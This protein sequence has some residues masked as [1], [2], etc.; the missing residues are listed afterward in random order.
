MIYQISPK[1]RQD[2]IV[3]QLEL[4]ENR[5]DQE[6]AV[7]ASRRRL[8]H[9]SLRH[10]SSAASSA[11]LRPD[12]EIGSKFLL[13]KLLFSSSIPKQQRAKNRRNECQRH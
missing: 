4:E 11:L 10:V 2:I 3:K 7:R 13:L 12:P 5:Q 8:I 6:G 1:W 9:I